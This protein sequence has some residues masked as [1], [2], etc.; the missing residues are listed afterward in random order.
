M[1]FCYP[2]FKKTLLQ[3]FSF[4]YIGTQDFSFFPSFLMYVTKLSGFHDTFSNFYN[5][6]Q[7]ENSS[8][9]DSFCGQTPKSIVSFPLW[10]LSTTVLLSRR[11]MLHTHVLFCH[12]FPAYI[13]FFCIFMN[14]ASL[15]AN[16][17]YNYT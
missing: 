16:I 17:L 15:V 8:F 6:M 2:F 3:I 7:N 14:F 5:N 9:R 4:C 13:I 11:D 1:L 10:H 12:S